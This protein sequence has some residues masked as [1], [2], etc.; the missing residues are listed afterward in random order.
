MQLARPARRSL[1]TALAASAL[2]ALLAV[3]N[4]AAAGGEPAAAAEAKPKLKADRNGNKV[5]DDLETRFATLGAGERTSGRAD[6]RHS[7]RARDRDA[8][9]GSRA[10]GRRVCGVGR[11]AMVDGFSASLTKGQVNALARTLKSSAS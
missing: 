6:E 4:G 9:H 7:R 1:L 8:R 2:A 10:G 5:F 3:A 11:F